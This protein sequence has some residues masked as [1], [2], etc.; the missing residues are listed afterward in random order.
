MS[1]SRNL[2]GWLL[3]G[4][5]GA[6][7]AGAAVLGVTQSPKTA[8]LQQAITNTLNAPS[9]S[10]VFTE[11]QP[12]GTQTGYLTYEA[13]DKLGGY[14]LVGQN[15]RTYIYIHGGY[16]YESVTVSNT[17]PTTHLVFTR[18]RTQNGGVNQV[19]P[20]QIY[21]TFGRKG[22][23]VS[24]SGN[25]YTKSLTRNGVTGTLTYTVTGQYIG[26]LTIDAQRT[27]VTVTISQVGTAPP[28]GLPKGSKVITSTPPLLGATSG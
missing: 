23:L 16:E 17:A 7:T 3:V 24:Q 12:I 27:L 9:Y 2:L 11:T 26:K 8:T 15:R 14:V 25:T 28:V 1:D 4:L 10:E 18:Q 5:V 6:V 19:D 13:P 20:A 21:L 22:R